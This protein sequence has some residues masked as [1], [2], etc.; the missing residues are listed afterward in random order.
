MFCQITRE[1]STWTAKSVEEETTELIQRKRIQDLPLL[2][3][4]KENDIPKLKELLE[5]DKCDPYQRGAV[6]E[7]A[8]HVS[9]QY[10]NLEAMEVLLDEAPQL[11]NQAMTSDLYRGQTAL[12]IAAVNQKVDLV[13]A[14]IRRGA[15]V[16]SPRATGSFFA[17][18]PKNLFYFGEHILS[19]ATCVADAEIVKILIDHGADM[20]NQDNLGNTVLHILVLQPNKSISCQ[21]FDFLL[22]RD[23]GLRGKALSEI[24]NKQGLTPLKLAAVEGNVV[25]FQ[26]LIQKKRKVQWSFGPINNMLYDMS[27]IDSWEGQESILELLASSNKSKAH[28]IM[29]IPPVKQLLQKKW[30]HHGR[31]YFLSLATLYV[32][33]MTCVSLCCVN[34]PIKP[35]EGNITD[36]RDITLFVQKTLQEAYV[37]TDDYLRLLGEIISVIGA[38]IF[39]IIELSQVQKIGL[40]YFLLRTFWKENFHMVRISFALLVLLVL[41]MRL[42]NTDGEVIPMSIALLLGWCYVMYFARGFQMLGPFTIIIQ[43]ISTSNLLTFGWLMGMVVCGYTLALYVTY[44]MVDPQAFGAYAPYAMCLLSTYELFLNALNGPANYSVYNPTMYSPIYSSFSVIAFLLMF[45][46][47]IAIMGDTQGDMA[48]KKDELWKA[49]IGGATVMIERTFPK[50]LLFGS[51]SAEHTLE[52]RRYLSVEERRRHACPSQNGEQSS[53]DSDEDI[54]PHEPLETEATNLTGTEER[55]ADDIHGAVDG[56]KVVHDDD[57]DDDDESYMG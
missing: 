19:F 52:E 42:T 5:D 32:F 25:M 3:A 4:A 51:K 54:P 29:N 39:L 38:I 26:H 31:T 15:D 20:W 22:S 1:I 21:M 45:N 18:S 30:Q 8:L 53:I 41:A 43:K 14:L 35:R 13:L 46:L 34:R 50:R 12:H 24:P 40:K 48:K 16:S 36:P 27:E 10:G 2:R 49:Q 9:V 7:T 56:G 17:L 23:C 47:L 57:D 44:Q 11:I 33:Y 28:K 6:G 55:R 37:T